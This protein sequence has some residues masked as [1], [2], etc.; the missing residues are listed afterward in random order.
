[1][2]RRGILL[3]VTLLAAAAV[4]TVIATRTDASG[5]GALARVSNPG[6]SVDLAGTPF[7]RAAGVRRGALLAV[8][9]GRAYYRLDGAEACFGTGPAAD[10]GEISGAECPRAEF[11]SPDRPV[12]DLSVYEVTTR[13][14]RELS[15]F[16]AEGIAADGV[17]SIGFLRPNGKIALKVPVRG[18][19]FS[20][21]AVPSGAV[22]GLVALDAS[23]QEL[24]R[25]P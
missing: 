23:D 11:P 15:L 18:N 20:T 3:A 5:R 6:R 13:G 12:L 19:V 25:S 22:K 8:R 9:G 2:R 17:S 14:T 16:R 24:W 4:A 1:M 21:S 10:V 7:A